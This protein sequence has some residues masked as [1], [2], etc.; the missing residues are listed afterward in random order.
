MRKANPNN[1]F[2][3]LL[4]KHSK[5]FSTLGYIIK[6][7]GIV[8][9]LMIFL[10]LFSLVLISVYDL[11]YYDTIKKRMGMD[12]YDGK[13]WSE[14][15]HKEFIES[16]EVEYYPYT[17]YKRIPNYEGKYVNLNKESIRKTHFQCPSTDT[18][19]I[20]AFGGSTMWGT[21]ARDI[22]TIPSFLSKYLCQEGIN[23]EITNFGE[24]GYTSTQEIIRLLLE[25]RKENYP[26]IV[27]FYDGVNDVF[28]SFQNRVAGLPQNIEN[29]KIEFNSKW[30]FNIFPNFN[31]VVNR[32]IK[33]LYGD[34]L[35]NRELDDNLNAETAD[36]YFNNIKIVKSL[37]KEYKF[38]SF[39]YWQ[40][41][42]HTKQHLSDD[43]K[44]IELEE[45]K[46]DYNLVLNIVK[47]SKKVKDLSQVF[48]DRNNTIFIDSVHISEE[49]N[50]IIAR[51]MSKGI[52]RYIKRGY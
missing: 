19:K 26:D 49:G 32:I 41:T 24:V 3:K 5:F 12:V 9:I 7:V 10:E 13:D 38:K 39:F 25:L 15:Y 23:V 37:E 29:R 18:I 51:E 21:G 50:S 35:I 52:L 6:F 28:S 42:L 44:R 43:E 48:D 33:T 45:R 46:E 34:S 47:K 31:R 4:K 22:G 1:R 20:F 14:Q 16:N 27:I 2:E 17:G 36:I 40:P 30:K 11:T 8:A